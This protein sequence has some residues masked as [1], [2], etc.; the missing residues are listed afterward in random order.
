[1]AD[2]VRGDIAATAMAEQIEEGSTCN[3]SFVQKQPEPEEKTMSFITVHF[4]V[5]K[6]PFPCFSFPKRSAKNTRKHD[7]KKAVTQPRKN[8]QTVANQS[9]ATG[10]RKRNDESTK[11]NYHCYTSQM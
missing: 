10:A 5:M 1:M 8:S 6:C 11:C 7:V 9:A 3:S 4:A 2:K